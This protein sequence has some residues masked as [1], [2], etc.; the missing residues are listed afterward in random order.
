MARRNPLTAA[1]STAAAF[2][3]RQP[4]LFWGPTQDLALSKIL[5]A[6]LNG[7]FDQFVHRC[8]CLAASV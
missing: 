6:G 8:V 2:M 7:L 1:I 5:N 4:Q 3:Q